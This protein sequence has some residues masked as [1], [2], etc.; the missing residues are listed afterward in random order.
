MRMKWKIKSAM[1][2]ILFMGIL[3]GCSEKENQMTSWAENAN[4]SDHESREELYQAALKED[5]LMIYS[6][7]SKFLM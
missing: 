2:L 7:S 5:T 3:T 4:L 6:V 1:I